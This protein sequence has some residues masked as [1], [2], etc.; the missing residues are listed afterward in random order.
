MRQHTII[1]F[2]RCIVWRGMSNSALVGPLYI[3]T[4][5]FETAVELWLAV[6]QQDTEE[7]NCLECHAVHNKFQIDR[8]KFETRS[9]R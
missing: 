7:N 8:P 4:H 9:L 6:K 5:V 1:R 2:A 3:D